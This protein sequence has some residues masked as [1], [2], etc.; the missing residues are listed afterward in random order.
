M[1]KERRLWGEADLDDS[2]TGARKSLP[3]HAGC[4]I[5]STIRI[6]RGVTDSLS[7]RRKDRKGDWRLEAGTRGRFFLFPASC[8]PLRREH[9]G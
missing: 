8:F 6:F 5:L 9:A 2:R 1:P 4:V 3:Y 7:Q